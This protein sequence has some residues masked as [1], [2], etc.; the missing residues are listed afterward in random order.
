MVTVFFLFVRAPFLWLF[1]IFSFSCKDSL[2]KSTSKAFRS[3]TSGASFSHSRT[4]ISDAGAAARQRQRLQLAG[5][6]TEFIR[7]ALLMEHAGEAASSCANPK[8]RVP[9]LQQTHAF[10]PLD[11]I[12]FTSLDCS[13]LVESTLSFVREER[14]GSRRES[15]I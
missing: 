14:R 7:A 11:A 8:S 13:P 4:R 12:R 3:S 2:E 15:S 10:F 6:V 1:S 5:R 9:C